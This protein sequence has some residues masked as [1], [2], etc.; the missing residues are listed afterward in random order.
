MK[1]TTEFSRREFF[2]TS[3]AVMA[4][5]SMAGQNAH[6][7]SAAGSPKARLAIDGGPKA[8]VEKLPPLVRWDYDAQTQPG[9]PEAELLTQL[10]PNDWLSRAKK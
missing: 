5:G 6:G 2:A 3:G 4:A 8:V 7:A 10:R 9:S 1:P